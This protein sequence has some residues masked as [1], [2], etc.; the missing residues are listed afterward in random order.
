[1]ESTETPTLTEQFRQHLAAQRR[2]YELAE[3]M[4]F[5]LW[6]PMTKEQKLSF[7]R[8]M[9]DVVQRSNAPNECTMMQWYLGLMRGRD[10]L[11]TSLD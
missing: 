6:K 5:Q 4:E 7:D 2:G 9:Q 11:G 3:I 8:L 1:M 10:E